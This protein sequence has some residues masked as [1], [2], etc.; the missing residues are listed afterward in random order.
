MK[1]NLNINDLGNILRKLDEN[2][3]LE[4]MTKIELSGG[5]LT[6]HG[7]ASIT[8]IPVDGLSGCASKGNNII[9]I[10]VKSK[11]TDGTIIKITGAKDKK[12]NIDISS[13]RYKELSP[14]GSLSLNQIKVNN[15]ECKLRID[16]DIIFKINTSAKNV[17]DL[18]NC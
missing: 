11:S 2:Y 3:D 9:H 13:T 5:W 7:K 12:F 8:K 6:M 15:E 14:G 16:N 4:L 10:K 17:E 1:Y 18:I